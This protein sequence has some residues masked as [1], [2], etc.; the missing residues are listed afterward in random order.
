MKKLILLTAL[1]YT[2]AA[3][4]QPHTWLVYGNAGI[5][6]NSDSYQYPQGTNTSWSISPGIGYQ[7]DKHITLGIQVSYSH[8]E[9][10]S[11]GYV[12]LNTASPI[13]EYIYTSGN[14]ITINWSAGA[15]FR[16]TQN[17]GQIFFLYGQANM[18]YMSIEVYN[19]PYYYYPVP[20]YNNYYYQP[21][22]PSASGIQA[23]V[24]PAIG[25]KVYKGLA[26][27]FNL[28]G[29]NYSSI[30]QKVD[31][32]GTKK[33]GTVQFTFGQ[34]VSIGISDNF[35]CHFRHRHKH[36]HNDAGSEYRQPDKK[37][38]EEDTNE[39]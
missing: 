5:S 38:T 15:F 4:A 33:A 8:I 19:T 18:A 24:F 37:S 28:G 7:V 14:S 3:Y 22:S 10:V 35:S 30:N 11:D 29:L 36:Q 2:V 20:F 6:Q 17:F 9:G 31:Y 1:L 26:L 27:N 25:A 16:Y 13:S 32:E 21:Y 34:Q 23:Q 12:L 39:Q